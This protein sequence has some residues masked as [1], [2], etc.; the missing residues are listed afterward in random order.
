[1]IARV[2][3]GI[4]PIGKADQYLEYLNHTVV[5]GCQAAGGNQGFFIFRELQGELAYFLL[6]SLWS[7]CDALAAFSDPDQA[8]VRQAPEEQ[9]FLVAFESVVAH[10]EVLQFS[11]PDDN[12]SL[13]PNF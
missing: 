4:T 10:Y 8:L 13:R 3:R 5:P 7:S 1:M 6:L 9:K 11:L 2:W 12:S